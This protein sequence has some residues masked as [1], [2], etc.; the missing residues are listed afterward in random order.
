MRKRSDAAHVLG[1]GDTHINST[2]ALA[3]PTSYWDDGG[4]YEISDDQRE[5]WRAWNDM[6]EKVSKVKRRDRPFYLILNGDLVEDNFHPTTQTISHNHNDLIK[7]AVAVFEP[8]CKIAD[9]V[10][11][12]RGTEAH[13]G[14]SGELEE[15]LAGNFDNVV[16]SRTALSWWHLRAEFG[17]AKFDISH[18]ASM[19]GLPWTEKNAANKVAAIIRSSYAALGEKEPQVV[20]RS[21][22]HRVSDSGINY[23]P[24]R[25]FTLPCWSLFTS[26]SYRIGAENRPPDLGALLFEIEGGVA[27][28]PRWIRYT[29]KRE[30]V[31]TE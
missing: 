7:H 23:L 8:L 9:S 4:S 24:M 16:P 18:H 20:L 15:R 22:V 1:I 6:L 3:M 29:V 10:F 21:H 27:N 11:F 17:G 2:R 26:Y 5:L 13:T 31:W 30:K 19:G 25:A 12:I 28:E 14:L